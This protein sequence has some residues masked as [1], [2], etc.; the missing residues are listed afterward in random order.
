[1]SV[2]VSAME[3]AERCLLFRD[4]FISVAAF[5]AFSFGDSTFYSA[6]LAF[7]STVEEFSCRNLQIAGLRGDS[8]EEEQQL[9]QSL[10]MYQQLQ[11]QLVPSRRQIVHNSA[12]YLETFIS[13]ENTKLSSVALIYFILLN[14]QS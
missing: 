7:C 2:L 10:K 8:S 14:F 1:M 13:R 5:L 9:T 6:F 12:W 11:K 3:R 4:V